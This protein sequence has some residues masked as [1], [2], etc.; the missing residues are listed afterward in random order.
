MPRTSR[1]SDIVAYIC[2]T[3]PEKRRDGLSNSRL[4]KLVYLADWTSVFREGGRPLTGIRCVFNRYGPWVAD[5]MDCAK[6]DD[7]FTVTK[8]YNMFGSPKTTV[9]FI[10][11]PQQAVEALDADTRLVIDSVV[12]LTVDMVYLDFINYVYETY[13]IVHGKRG[14][15]LQ[16]ERSAREAREEARR[17]GKKPL[18]L[19]DFGKV[20]LDPYHWARVR[21]AV[22]M[23][24]QRA[25]LNKPFTALT[26]LVDVPSTPWPDG[27]D[28]TLM[29]HVTINP[30]I[31]VRKTPDQSYAVTAE[32]IVDVVVYYYRD[33]EPSDKTETA[34][35]GLS[36]VFDVE[37]SGDNWTATPR[38]AANP[39]W[40]HVQR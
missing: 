34:R 28:A 4:T 24:A 31:D 23:A 19:V 36:L 35:L 11:D 40:E 12:S 20:G 18:R 30:I 16:L 32:A 15:Y 27:P 21:D 25:L 6:T 14:T 22:D 8:T 17:A 38:A 3:Y 10:G 5:V 7:R 2:A 13:P 37:G 39:T 26:E 9:G 1:T 33:D 29:P